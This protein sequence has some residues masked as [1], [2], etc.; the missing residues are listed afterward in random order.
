MTVTWRTWRTAAGWA[1]VAAALLVPAFVLRYPMA[2]CVVAIGLVV[3]ATAVW[4]VARVLSIRGLRRWTRTRWTGVD[5]GSRSW[6]WDTLVL[7]GDVRVIC[8]WTGHADG[9]PVTFGQIGWS[10]RALAGAVDDND[11][12]GTFVIVRL[13]QPEPPMAARMPLR[14]VGSSPR[15]EQPALRDAFFSGRIPAFTVR[16]DELFTVE[17]GS[18]TIEAAA[19]VHAV[20]R[21]LLVVR[22]LDLGPD[23]TTVPPD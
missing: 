7:Q 18:L 1:A 20:R 19:A 14:F 10:G 16:D 23:T 2:R 15:L 21:A 3:L 5:P 6:P 12:Q 17:Q 22:L 4:T 11:G 8:A 9:F 13:P